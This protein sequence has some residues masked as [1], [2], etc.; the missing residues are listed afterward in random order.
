MLEQLIERDFPERGR[1]YALKGLLEAGREMLPLHDPGDQEE[2][3][4]E[5]L[6]IPG[7]NDGRE[8]T[9]ATPSYAGSLIAPTNFACRVAT[10]A[11]RIQAGTEKIHHSFFHQQVVVTL[12][13]KVRT[14]AQ[15]EIKARKEFT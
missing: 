9:P 12:N 1:A 3:E 11:F 8:S 2:V 5:R 4:L 10:P 6:V 14:R 15:V 13:Q 7:V